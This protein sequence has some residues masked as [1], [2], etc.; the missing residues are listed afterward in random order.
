[1]KKKFNP[2]L[3]IVSLVIIL[4]AGYLLYDNFF[5]VKFEEIPYSVFYK[6]VQDGYKYQ[7]VTITEN[8][9]KFTDPNNKD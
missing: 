8:N 9:I 1:M 7:N 3:L 5:R 6:N 2:F 4:S